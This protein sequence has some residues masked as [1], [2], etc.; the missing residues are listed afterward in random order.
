MS[1]NEYKGHDQFNIGRAYANTN[2]T[3][4][5]IRTYK[6]K[7]A[8]KTYFTVGGGNITNYLLTIDDAIATCEVT[9]CA[10]STA[11][12]QSSVADEITKLKGLLDQGAITQQ[13]YDSTKKKLLSKE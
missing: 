1:Y 4:K 10:Q 8:P 5:K 11:S 12:T 7:G 6:V 9:P 3:V 2:V 13:E